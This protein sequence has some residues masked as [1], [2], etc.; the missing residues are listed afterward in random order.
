M[1]FDY[2]LLVEI[3]L[4]KLILAELIL[5][6]LILIGFLLTKL[7]LACSLLARYFKVA[8]CVK[9]LKPPPKVK[10]SPQTFIGLISH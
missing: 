8:S 6:K 9:L 3:L 1:P 7:L 4:T 2:F 10:P 5:T